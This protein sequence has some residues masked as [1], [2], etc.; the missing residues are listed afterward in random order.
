MIH[1]KIYLAEG[2]QLLINDVMLTESMSERMRGLLFRPPLQ[3][4][5]ALLIKPCS[6][7]HTFGMS[8]PLDLVFLSKTFKVNKIVANLKPLRMASSFGS[9]MVIE[10]LAG[11]LSNTPITNNTQLI[12]EEA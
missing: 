9:H 8:Y 1:G 6:S 5:Q 4:N 7:I 12:W 2:K 11:S 10:M 3:S